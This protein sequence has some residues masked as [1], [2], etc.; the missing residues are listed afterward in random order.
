MNKKNLNFKKLFSEKLKKSNLIKNASEI[1]KE[2]KSLA[3]TIKSD[4]KKD[5]EFQSSLISNYFHILFKSKF[6]PLIL[7]NLTRI[8]RYAC[9]AERL[10][11]NNGKFS[12]QN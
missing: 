9:K 6:T 11:K 2:I 1:V 5:G 8:I 12:V 10:F 3:K 4:A 7:L